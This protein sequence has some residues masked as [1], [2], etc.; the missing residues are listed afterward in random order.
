MVDR[1]NK[2]IDDA[3]RKDPI[4]EAPSDLVLVGRV[5]GLLSGVGKQL[6]SEVNLFSTLMPY[7]IKGSKNPDSVTP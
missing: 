2:E 5:M 7:L 1:F 6:G 4:V 3:M